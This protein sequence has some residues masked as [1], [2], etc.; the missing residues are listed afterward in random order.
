MV[1]N[2][3]LESFNDRAAAAQKA[4]DAL[5]HV[6]ILVNNAALQRTYENFEDI[7]DKRRKSK[8]P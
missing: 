7:P 3:G 1:T 2:M 6:N 5:G 4:I 8:R